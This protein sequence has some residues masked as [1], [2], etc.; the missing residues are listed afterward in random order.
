MK[1][2]KIYKA[3]K[4]SVLLVVLLG[5]LIPAWITQLDT[6]SETITIEELMSGN[7]NLWSLNLK[8]T[9]KAL[10][11]YSCRIEERSKG[12][13]YDVKYYIPFVPLNWRNNQKIENILVLNTGKRDPK[14]GL[15]AAIK[16]LDFFVD[17]LKS[18]ADSIQIPVKYK[19]FE[20]DKFKGRVMNCL[21]KKEGI[22]LIK[23]SDIRKLVYNDKGSLFGNILLTIFAIALVTIIYLKIKGARART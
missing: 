17:S 10:I 1:A 6:G 14:E 3:L 7:R 16:K 15:D 20:F 8:I 19:K 11:Q 13:L 5:V 12:K 21:R 2:L 4:A 23:T 18:N 9:G 22:K